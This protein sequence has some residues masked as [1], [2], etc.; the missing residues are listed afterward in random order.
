LV[1]GLSGPDPV[2]LD[3]VSFRE[4]VFGIEHE[5]GDDEIRASAWEAS[6]IPYDPRSP[7]VVYAREHSLGHPETVE[8]SFEDDGVAYRGQGFSRAI[9]FHAQDQPGEMNE[10]RW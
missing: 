5:P 8:F 3:V 1:K 6:G 4:Q 9:I 10:I 7:F 2:G